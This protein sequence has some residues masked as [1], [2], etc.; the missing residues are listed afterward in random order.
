MARSERGGRGAIGR[1]RPTPTVENYLKTMRK[2]AGPD[3]WITPRALAHRLGVS[4]ASVTSMLKHLRRIGLAAYTPYRGARLT[5][6]GET[7]ALRVVRRHRLLERFLTDV[8]GV[9][10]DEVD[11]E[12][13]ALEHA[14]SDR[15]ERHIDRLLSHPQVDPHG[16]PIPAR[17]GRGRRTTPERTHALSDAPAG[18]AIVAGASDAD[19]AALR[20]LARLG[21]VPG[22]RLRVLGRTARG[23]SVE[24]RIGGR[25]ARVPRRAARTVFLDSGGEEETSSIPNGGVSSADPVFRRCSSGG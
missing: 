15:L 19:P 16:D 21:L 9:P 5:W 13:E 3:G 11:A 20:R 6:K 1:G 12:A 14:L 23:G 10:W 8:V 4:G 17:A 18:A 7:E 25:A 2:Q 24:I 22:A